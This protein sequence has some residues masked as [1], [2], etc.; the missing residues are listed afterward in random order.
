MPE[1]RLGCHTYVFSEYGWDPAARLEEILALIAESGYPAVELYYPNLERPDWYEALTAARDQY[2]L[3]II[4]SSHG[5][6]LYDPT[7]WAELR[8]RL[9]VYAG[10]LSLLGSMQCGYS[11]SGKRLAQRT[12]KEN[13][14]LLSA[15]KELAQL[16][17]GHGVTLNYHT[18]GE[19][20]ED[21]QFMID[22][23]PPDLLALGPDLDWLRF[24]G[25]DPVSFLRANAK[26]L[27]MLHARDYKL[28]GQRTWALGEGDA[29]YANLAKVLA[30][31]NFKGDFVVELAIPPGANPA[32]RPLAEILKQSRE[33]IRQTMGL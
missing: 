29:D 25:T 19:P 4:G 7:Q 21:I 1:Y 33:H 14:H 5:G 13:A 9:L 20:P 26:Q 16:F 30:E 23:I 17:R 6:N 22:N 8:Q 24:G 3:R 10:Q 12:D 2:N 15:W 31:I 32:T 18:H 27:V 11:I 28:G